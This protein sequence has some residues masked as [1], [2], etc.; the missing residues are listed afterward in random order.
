MNQE[1]SANSVNV[2]VVGYGGWGRQC[3]SYL[4]SRAPGLNLFGVAAR[5]PDT[6]AR[7]KNDYPDARI[8]DD[9]DAALSDTNVD[10]VVLATPNNTHADFA[11]AALQ[12]QKHV[13]SDKVFCLNLADC[14]RMTRAAE[15][16]GKVLTVFQNRRWDGDF[17]TVQSLI[18]SGD[19][20]ELRWAEM[21]WQGMGAWGGWRGK[22]ESGGGRFYDLGAHLLDQLLLLF[23]QKIETVYARMLHDFPETDIDSEAFLVVTFAG[24]KT[25]VCDLSSR[26]AISKPRFYIRGTEG[27]FEKFGLDPQEDAM[28]A[29]D[30]DSARETPETFGRLKTRTRDETV[31]TQPGCWRTYYERLA[32]CL[33]QN[34]PP[35]VP[36]SEARR[37]IAVMDA[38]KRS[39]Q[40]Q[41]VIAA[42]DIETPAPK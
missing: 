29:G 15:A 16:S 6:Q 30:I 35:P 5:N 42:P 32:D 4:I 22:A 7:A 21:A 26:A 19:L 39:A 25:A 41:T 31:P 27:T 36:L 33:L 14:D 8:Y 38:A 3:H 2:V 12:A 34:A 40:T 11:V 20:G 23:P 17:Q 10:V 13:V 18:K 37:V 28:K 1:N 24:G 9:L